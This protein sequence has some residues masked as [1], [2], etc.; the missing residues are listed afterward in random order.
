MFVVL[1]LFTM[2]LMLFVQQLAISPSYKAMLATQ[3]QSH[4]R[5]T[6]NVEQTE[7]SRTRLLPLECSW[8]IRS[9]PDCSDCSRSIQNDLDY[10][11]FRLLLWLVGTAGLLGLGCW[12]LRF[13]FLCSRAAGLLASRA[14]GHSL[15]SLGAGLPGWLLAAAGFL[16]C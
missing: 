1:L 13:L 3:W 5:K 8:S 7:C 4:L 6:N 11:T 14:A 15:G 10:Y 16:G 2:V 12:A 9:G